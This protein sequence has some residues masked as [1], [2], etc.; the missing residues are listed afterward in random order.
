MT[1]KTKTPP[2]ANWDDDDQMGDEHLA[3]GTETNEEV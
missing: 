3:Q 1:E 2:H